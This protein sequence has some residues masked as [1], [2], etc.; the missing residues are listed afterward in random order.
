MRNSN[1]R[2]IDF[3][4]LMVLNTLHQ[5]RSV[6]RTADR[7]AVT[8]PT[9]SG[10]LK[11]LRQIFEDDLFV[12]TSHGV[13]P[14]PRAESLAPRVAEIVEATQSLFVQNSFD[15]ATAEF[16]LTFCG[17]DYLQQTFIGELAAR[18]T[19][20]APGARISIIGRP[21]AHLETL[22]ARGEIDLLFSMGDADL[23]HFPDQVLFSEDLVCASSYQGHK[24]GQH[25]SLAELCA[26]RHI[27]LEPTRTL[28]TGRIVDDALASK[29]FTR[30][31]VLGTPNFATLFQ[32]MRNGEFIAFLPRQ[33]AELYSDTLRF[34]Q[35]DLTIPAVNVI[36][37]W[38]PRMTKDAMHTWV[39][40][41][42]QNTVQKMPT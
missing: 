36:A 28:S 20:A 4:L 27:R 11:R 38:H 3:N 5:E 15:P 8:Q 35:T 25:L 32:A 7:L 6:T 34:L 1:I 37:S 9:V 18:I 24:E 14:T 31:I 29:G 22:M 33:I 30:N 19:R 39:Q 13:I 16:S 26:L 41:Q 2:Q 42:L 23:P 17:S 21:D 12:R 10:N 40:K